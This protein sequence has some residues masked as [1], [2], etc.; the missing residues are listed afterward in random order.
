M[1]QQPTLLVADDNPDD[2]FLLQKAFT[3]AKVELP[4]SVVNDGTEAIAYLAGEGEYQNRVAHPFPDVLLLDL[5]MP[6]RNGF[7]VLQWIRQNS[8]CSRLIV[9]VFTASARLADIERAYDLGANSFV[10]KP[11][12][13][14]ELA[15]FVTALQSWQRFVRP[16]PMVPNIDR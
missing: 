15:D 14:D 8:R 16:A 7:E 10:V 13:I 4:F 9:H 2:V 12:R 3:K 1:I 6:R 11:T 5:N